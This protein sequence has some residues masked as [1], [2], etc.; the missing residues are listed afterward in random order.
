MPKQSRLKGA[1]SLILA[2][3]CVLLFGYVAHL[4]IG[5]ALG[6]G[7]YGI[8]G[9]VLSIQTI[10]GLILTLGV[11]I[12]VSRFVAQDE[13][14]AR[15]ILHQALRIQAGIALAVTAALALLAPFISRALGD[16]R[17]SPYIQ[18][19]ALV[20]FL[21]AFYQLFIQFASGLHFFN[22]QAALT[23]IYATAK[24][25]SA[26]TL[27]Y[28]FGVYGAFSGFAIG[29]VIATLIGWQWTRHLG[30]REPHRL[31]LRP[32]LA[33][34]GMY[35]LILMGLQL[36]ISLDLFMVKAYLVDD[37]AA[38]LYNAAVTL[39]RIPYMLLQGLTF[40]LLPSISAL[41]RNDASHDEAAQFI[42][43]VLRYL[44]GL[45]LPA[46]ALAAA[47]S[48]SLIRLFFSGEYLAAAEPLTILMVGLSSLAFY[49]LLAN[50]VSG[51]GRARVAL[52][53]TG[54]ILIISAAAGAMLIPRFGLIGAAWQTTIAG[55]VG[56]V[57]ISAYTF[58]T[59]RIPVPIRSS[60]NC[61]IATI[62]AVSITYVWQASPATLMLQYL[63]AA[64]LY[65]GV[66]LLLGEV[67]RADR[68]RLAEMHPK[69]SWLAPAE[70]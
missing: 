32:F 51:A 57:L 28:I 17:L 67:S 36:L 55:L 40:V 44:I 24:L 15:S 20:I 16:V 13:K 10:A 47:T 12:A 18:F 3:A 1:I 35:V 11:P 64:G 2:Q 21:Q 34:A 29:A 68:Q 27:I 37:V 70:V 69:L 42:R 54:S 60:I 52:I 62:V 53:I 45:I 38:G 19:A 50:I 58:R 9:V 33:F 61:I 46:A 26:L 5:R 43:D 6:P 25:I 31:P 41:T 65:L 49:L 30:G 56:L 4:W 59:F 7:P 23:A 22:R 14:H 48:K 63:L 66:L 39:S 8:Y